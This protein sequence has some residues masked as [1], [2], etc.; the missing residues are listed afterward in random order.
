MGFSDDHWMYSLA[1]RK[2]LNAG[3]GDFRFVRSPLGGGWF[4]FLPPAT[5]P[6]SRRPLAYLG[7]AEASYGRKPEPAWRR[8]LGYKLT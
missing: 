8:E 1:G 2:T 7:C 5:V 3:V 4:F 6:K